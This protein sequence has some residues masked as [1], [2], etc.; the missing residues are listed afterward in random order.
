[1]RI[2]V[3]RAA[4][5]A[6]IVAV[7]IIGLP[8]AF[9]LRTQVEQDI[10]ARLKTIAANTGEVVESKIGAGQPLGPDMFEDIMKKQDDLDLQIEVTVDK[11][12]YRTGPAP[13]GETL[14]VTNLTAVSGV[15]T[16]VRVPKWDSVRL[17]IEPWIYLL[18]G[19]A[20]AVSGASI[21]G[22]YMAN[23]MVRPLR[24]LTMYAENIGTG[25]QTRSNWTDVGITE[26]DNLAFQ[27][28]RSSE[29]LS[30]RLTAER[31]L[32]SDASH[33]LRTPLTALS[34]RL[35]YIM[36]MSSD[37][38]VRE[39]A[40]IALEQVDRLTQVVHDLINAPRAGKSR[41]PD[42]IDVRDILKQQH[43]EWRGHF[44]QAGRLLEVRL[45]D[46]TYVWAH[47]GPLAQVVATLVE[48]SLHHGAGRTLVKVRYGSL[49]RQRD[50]VVIEV[51][52][53]GPGVPPELGNRIF[54]RSVQGPNSKGTGV[55]L[56]LA[57]DLVADDGGRLEIL[58]SSPPLFGV[59]LAAAP[60]Y[61]KG[62]QRPKVKLK[63]PKFGRA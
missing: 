50:T 40:R 9:L 25:G 35:D 22:L 19:A 62:Q 59:F 29:R 20:I 26:L 31:R 47:S 4:V 49:Q 18:F 51:S 23:R 12:V 27:L 39:E 41:N 5:A 7:C 45:P 63:N 3:V 57:R 46:P 21:M 2:R 54:D 58:Q 61:G 60:A 8:F 16:T 6:A 14:A 24:D 13:S 38:D 36:E 44:R 53:E 32:A 48:N 28:T 33:Q 56:S 42:A 37:M 30:E 55:G 34:M 17:S 52:D 10:E 1:M 11:S 15:F 43:E